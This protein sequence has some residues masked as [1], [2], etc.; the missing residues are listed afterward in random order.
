[1]RKYLISEKYDY[2]EDRVVQRKWFKINLN[3]AIFVEALLITVPFLY[4]AYVTQW[5]DVTREVL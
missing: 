5:I 3:V 1:M 2:Y 4:V